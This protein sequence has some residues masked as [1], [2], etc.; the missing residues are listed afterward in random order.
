MKEKTRKQIKKQSIKTEIQ[1]VMLILV[2]SS[3][4]VLG[5]IS[6]VTNLLST[7]ALLEDTMRQLA[8]IAAERV[9][10]ELAD[11]QD[12]VKEM[13]RTSRLAAMSV[14][15]DDK[16]SIV[17]QKAEEHGMVRG[18]ILDVNGISIFDGTDLSGT[19]YYKRTME[20]EV[21][22]LEPIIENGESHII[23]AAPL[24]SNGQKDTKVLGTIYMEPD[25]L[26]LNEIVEGIQ[27]SKNGSAYM[28]D[29]EG[30]VIAHK[31]HE[32]VLKQENS[33][34]EAKTDSSL[35]A[36]ADLESK[37]VAGESGF[38]TYFYGG[39]NKMLAYAPVGG[40]DGWS[41]A[42][43]APVND[44]M[45]ATYLSI[46]VIVLILVAA[47]GIATYLAK[48]LAGGIGNGVNACAERL[49]KLAEGDLQTEVPVTDRKD[50][51]GM[52]SESTG[53][54]VTSMKA[55]IDDI[56]YLL[57]EMAGGNFDVH[58]NAN[59]Y[60]V[61]DF[62]YILQALR[63]INHSLSDTMLQIM[64][65]ADQVSAGAGQLAQSATELAEGA[66]DQAG[67]VEELTAT[68]TDVSEQVQGNAA[69]AD[70]TSKEAQDIGKE[71]K[72]SSAQMKE[73]TQAMERI[74]E[75][76][77][78]IGKIIGSIEEI[79][80]QTNLLALNAS[81]EAARAGEAGKG[82]A[83]VAG[84]IGQ[85][86]KQSQ[87]AVENTRNLIETALSEVENGN[88]IVEKTSKSLQRVIDQIEEV[89][90]AVEG[91]SVSCEGQAQTMIQLNQGVEQISSVV[92]SNSAA[93][94]ESSA[95][96]EELYAQATS[97]NELIGKFKLKKTN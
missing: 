61:G 69:A 49:K 59:A 88:A 78:E 93:A 66:T 87:M 86:A 67:A 97:L 53:Q 1:K 30:T 57:A 21:C 11:F 54:I 18:D 84:E 8:T 19:E 80:S 38:G 5:T 39:S 62:A 48:K 75:A 22:I 90:Q 81:I 77:S 94:Q 70:N 29:E 72:G 24:W 52:L 15:A 73:M 28:L 51:I 31:N 68:I 42:I 82:F 26:F 4:V 89:V 60:Y 32:S 85:L 9:Q 23:I 36:V 17:Q 47:I 35:K 43:T 13:G 37:M 16:K 3:L 40:T 25:P 83:V 7:N 92:Q 74:S 64:S 14:S 58:S 91:V 2:I 50:E 76:S 10:W 96:S 63:E 44:F 56:H 45:G 12:V 46:A 41:I 79:A 34:E 71:A 95:T 55:I 20:G 65:A 6:C 27:V 33:M